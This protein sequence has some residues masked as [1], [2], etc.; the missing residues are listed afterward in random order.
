MI[1]LWIINIPCLFLNLA[2]GAASVGMLYFSAVVIT[3]AAISIE[4][5]KRTMDTPKTLK[6]IGIYFAM[7]F[8]TVLI[9]ACVSHPLDFLLT[10]EAAVNY[11][12]SINSFKGYIAFY[13]V[14]RVIFIMPIFW[15]FVATFGGKYKNELVLKILF[16][17]IASTLVAI[18]SQNDMSVAVQT[19]YKRFLT[20]PL[21]GLLSYFVYTECFYRSRGAN[22][23]S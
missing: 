20:Y 16:I 23:A 2:F 22:T 3:D 4:E 13:L 17:I 5:L 9:M 14:Y 7:V 15:L 10:Y 6:D 11:N 1:L 8:I 19:K 21:S 12:R 18:I